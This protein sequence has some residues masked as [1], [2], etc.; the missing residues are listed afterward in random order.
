MHSLHRFPQH[1]LITGSFVARRMLARLFSL[2]VVHAVCHCVARKKSR[3]APRSASLQGRPLSRP[4]RS[5]RALYSRQRFARH[6]L[7]SREWLFAPHERSRGRSRS[8]P[9]PPRIHPR[10]EQKLQGT[11]LLLALRSSAF[12]SSFYLRNPR[13][14]LPA[15]TQHCVLPILAG[16]VE[17]YSSRFLRVSRRRRRWREV[18]RR[19]RSRSWVRRTAGPRV[20][21]WRAE[22]R[23]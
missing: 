12:F 13:L 9:G 22:E 18:R 16:T 20:R 3:N 4:A 8:Q 21:L 2:G 15:D 7:L 5:Q 1:H 6:S 17:G 14:T 19:V 10:L 11:L 23:V